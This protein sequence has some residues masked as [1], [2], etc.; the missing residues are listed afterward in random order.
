MHK[1][2]VMSQNPF[3]TKNIL[4]FFLMKKKKLKFSFLT[5][6]E[7]NYVSI[8]VWEKCLL[9]FRMN[10]NGIFHMCG[11]ILLKN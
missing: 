3:K 8:T 11:R 10:V 7:I 2:R 6:P 5:E 4:L 1:L 9:L